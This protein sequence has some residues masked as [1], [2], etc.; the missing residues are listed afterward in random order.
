M[1][2]FNIIVVGGGLAGPLLASGLL[3]KGIKVNLYERLQEDA[4][5]DGYT[6]RVAQPCLQ[7]FE[8]CLSAEEFGKIKRRMGHFEDNQDTTPIWY[9]HKMNPL[10]NMSRFSTKYHESGHEKVRVWFL[11]GTSV[12]GDILIAADGSHSKSV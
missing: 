6:I 8:D 12:D 9:D 2:N 5:R 1:S 4:K 3:Q 7:A 10:L 11:D